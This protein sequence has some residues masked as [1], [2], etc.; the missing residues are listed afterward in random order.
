MTHGKFEPATGRGSDG[1]GITAVRQQLPNILN[2]EGHLRIRSLQCQLADQSEALERLAA[3]HAR[4]LSNAY[5]RLRELGQLK[6]DFLRMISHEI[7]TPANGV[8]GVGTLILDLCP[9]SEERTLYA[10]LLEQSGLRLRNLIDDTALIGDMENLTMETTTAI[11]FP[12]L[13]AQVSTSLPDIQTSI[14]QP[15]GVKT[16][17]LNGYHPLLKR[18]MESILLLATCF[19]GNKHRA[20]GVV[21][22][23]ETVLRVRLELDALSLSAAQV[24]EFFDLE[25]HVRSVSTAE[26]LGLA[27]V[28]AYQI[29]CAFGGNLRLVNAAADAGYLEASFLRQ[30]RHGGLAAVADLRGRNQ[31]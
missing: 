31:K 17:P 21:S 26:S 18:A 19:S 22:V 12:E 13:L 11:S 3:E 1:Q 10:A 23:E 28:V 24:A 16:F 20:H 27:P 30:Q 7:R 29:L 6:N 9:A 8:L 4:E 14:E 25:S 15:S 2:V 5:V